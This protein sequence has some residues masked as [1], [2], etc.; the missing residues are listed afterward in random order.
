MG[1]DEQ[2]CQ[3][4]NPSR[5]AILFSSMTSKLAPRKAWFEAKLSASEMATNHT[6]AQLPAGKIRRQT[7][8]LTVKT[9]TR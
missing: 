5:P 3:N 2:K 6:H 4:K 8:Q 9:S 1:N 7:Q